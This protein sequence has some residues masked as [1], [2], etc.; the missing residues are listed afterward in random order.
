MARSTATGVIIR[1]A[2]IGDM[3]AVCDL[4]NALIPTT[5]IAWTE[6]EQTLA[7]REVWFERQQRRGFPVLVADEDD[8][9][10]GFT[11]Y[12]DFRGDGVW[13]GYRHTVEHTIHVSE[14][15]WGLG[16]GRALLR[17][18][19]HRATS[20][21]M[22]VMVA[23]IDGENTESIRFHERLGYAVVAR[24]PE[25]GRKFDRWLELVLMQRILDAS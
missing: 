19:E 12:A 15:A 8:M 6:T 22:H 4:Y 21:G 25:V 13:P 9:V 16:V 3:P 2:V 10:I 14:S 20:A 17:E 11:S 5:T 23:A 1:D 7:Q 18:L 24:M